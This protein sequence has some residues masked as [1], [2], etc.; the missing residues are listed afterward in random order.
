VTQGRLNP[1]ALAFAQWMRGQMSESQISQRALGKRI[2]PAQPERGRRQ[3]VRHLSGAHYPSKASRGAYA[4]VF[5]EEFLDEDDEEAD[6]VSL[7]DE[8]LELARAH[9][10]IGR[11]LD[12]LVSE[13]HA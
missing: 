7:A 4:E 6:P 13:A 12:R 1:K 3:V 9:R 2:D 8:L 10:A 11:R 5:G